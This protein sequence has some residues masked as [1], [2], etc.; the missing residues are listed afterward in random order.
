MDLLV[1]ST[2]ILGIWAALGPLVGVRYGH[3]LSKQLQIEHWTTDNK[4]Q[5]FRE[6]LSAITEAFSTIVRYGSAGIASGPEEQRARDMAESTSFAILR[7]RLFI[8]RE[9]DELKAIHRWLEATRD[10]DNHHDITQFTQRF[11]KLSSD[12]KEA[13]H[14]IMGN[15]QAGAKRSSATHRQD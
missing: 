12:I 8:E 3:A 14:R 7:D 1:W 10:F 15:P 11:A 4:K 5:E 9:L 2:I 6:V 13:A